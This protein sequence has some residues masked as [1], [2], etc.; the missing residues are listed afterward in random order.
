MTFRTFALGI[1]GDPVPPVAPLVTPDNP[2]AAATYFTEWD[3]PWPTA[4]GPWTWETV[5][6][7]PIPFPGGLIRF[8][9]DPAA[10]SIGMNLRAAVNTPFPTGPQSGR[11]AM[12]PW[13]GIDVHGAA[14]SASITVHTAP[15]GADLQAD[16]D[17]G[18]TVIVT[19]EPN[20]PA[21]LLYDYTI[22]LSWPPTVGVTVTTQPVQYAAPCSAEW[23]WLT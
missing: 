23:E 20:P 16:I 8:G 1:D 22:H 12:G 4:E 3:P 11:V 17:P 14:V 19:R 13:A 2:G 18:G 15:A 21:P 10:T 6:G 9:G 7:P 5:I